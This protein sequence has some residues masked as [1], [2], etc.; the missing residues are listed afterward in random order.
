MADVTLLKVDLTDATF[1]APFGGATERADDAEDDDG[2]E[3]EASRARGAAALVGLAFLVAG[4]LLVKRVLA[5]DRGGDIPSE[6]DA[7][8]VDIEA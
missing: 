1:N 6:P 2:F 8:A 4:A 7:A 3:E 5:D